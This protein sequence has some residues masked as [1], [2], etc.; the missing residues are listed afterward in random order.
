[1]LVVAVS[2]FGAAC[3]S[4]GLPNSYVDQ[5]RRA[6]RQF[7]EACEDSLADSSDDAAAYCQCAFGELREALTFEEFKALDDGLR[8]NP[9]PSELSGDALGAFR[10]A[11]PLLIAC[12]EHAVG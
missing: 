11:E 3:T 1:M 8:T 2:L 6:E 10:I 7:V 12:A 9:E 5:D 4:E